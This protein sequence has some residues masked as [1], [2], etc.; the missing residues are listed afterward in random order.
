MLKQENDYELHMVSFRNKKTGSGYNVII[1]R[2]LNNLC[3]WH[4]PVFE[5]FVEDMKA[6]LAEPPPD[7]DFD[8]LC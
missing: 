7:D 1:G 2:D 3:P 5:K 8:D 4:V 6:K